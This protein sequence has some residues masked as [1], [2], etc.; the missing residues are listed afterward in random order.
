[1]SLFGNGMSLSE[2]VKWE[3]VVQILKSLFESP[4]AALAKVRTWELAQRK[5]TDAQLAALRDRDDG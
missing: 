1:M 2:L 4:E 3:P 5:E